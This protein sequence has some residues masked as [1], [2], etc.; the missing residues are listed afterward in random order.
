MLSIRVEKVVLYFKVSF[1]LEQ[2]RDH[3]AVC[4]TSCLKKTCKLKGLKKRI[5]GTSSNVVKANQDR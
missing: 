1:S 3:E 4:P 5:K 2:P